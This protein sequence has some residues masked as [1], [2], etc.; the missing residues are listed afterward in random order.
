MESSEDPGARVV[1]VEPVQPEP[2]MHPFKEKENPHPVD[3][4]FG[5]DAWKDSELGAK[6]EALQVKHEQHIVDV[7]Q[8]L[9]E[10][11]QRVAAVESKLDSV[12]SQ[13]ATPQQSS[14]PALD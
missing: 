13:A 6:H 9:T 5:H 4:L 2:Y 11:D 1:V 14:Q 8:K 3:Q 7:D 12:A 10:V